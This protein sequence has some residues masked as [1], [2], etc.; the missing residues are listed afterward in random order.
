ML[1][2]FVYGTTIMEALKVR[3]H[4]DSWNDDRI[5]E[6]A[7]DVKAGFAR[8]EGQMREG[9]AR[10]EGQIKEVEGRSAARTDRLEDRLE[11]VQYW[12]WGICGTLVVGVIVA[13]VTRFA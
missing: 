9:F 8:V 10:V 12:I 6:L 2:C 7:R 5:G 13:V 4:V 11:R 1:Q 3:E